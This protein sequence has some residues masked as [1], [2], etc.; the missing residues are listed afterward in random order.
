MDYI[1]KDTQISFRSNS[2]LVSKAKEIFSRNNI[3]MSLALNEFLNR[4]VE[5]NAL[6]FAVYDKEAERVFSE[7]KSEIGR[8]IHDLE[9][10]DYLEANEVERK[11]NAG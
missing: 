2:L 4:T 8:A 9:K 11:W 6:P 5:E 3:D 1:V 10:N 7:F